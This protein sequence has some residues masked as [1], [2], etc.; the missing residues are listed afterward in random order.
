MRLLVVEDNPTLADALRRGL[1]AEGFDVDLTDNGHDGLWRAREFAYDVIVLDILLPGVNGYEICRT[2]R[3]EGVRTPI[4]MLTAKDGEDDEAEG[5]DLGADDYLTKPFSFTVLVARLHAL[6]RRSNPVPSSPKIVAG[7]LT[8]DT[9]TR[10]CSIDDVRVDLSGR[11]F[12][13]LEALGRRLGQPLTRDELL[14]LV[15]GA[16]HATSSN[17]VDV[18]VGYVRRK[19][20]QAGCR[21]GIVETV[22]GI[23]YR[24]VK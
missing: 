1:V 18:Y 10:T 16:D 14:D 17:V 23:G 5:L 15:W 13:V 8:L 19:L 11:E 12:A 9:M 20:D 22:R 21:A 4:I 24:L 7:P 6:I 2:L 3:G